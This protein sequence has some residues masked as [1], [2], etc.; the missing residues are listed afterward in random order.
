MI[1]AQV[2][3]IVSLDDAE[4]TRTDM[5]AERTSAVQDLADNTSSDSV[6]D[7][8]SSILLLSSESSDA[9]T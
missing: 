7:A 2:P 9:E 4:R 5:L 6:S 1:M 8:G 3:H